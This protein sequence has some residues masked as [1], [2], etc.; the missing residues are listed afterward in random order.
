MIVSPGSIFCLT[1]KEGLEYVTQRD[2]M[3]RLQEHLKE[4]EVKEREKTEKK[5][6]KQLKIF[7]AQ[8]IVIKSI[9]KDGYLDV[10]FGEPEI[11]KDVIVEFTVYDKRAKRDEYDSRMQ[12]K[13]IIEKSLKDTN[14]KLMSDG[15]YCK[16]GILKG[17]LK[18]EEES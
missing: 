1:D 16:L 2:G 3:K 14:W 15:I 10:K 6:V 17:R 11:K 12:L 5:K 13:K 8:K 18:G 7:E 9:E 4:T